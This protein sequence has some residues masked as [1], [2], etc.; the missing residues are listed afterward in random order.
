FSPQNGEKQKRLYAK[1]MEELKTQKWRADFIKPI[2]VEAEQEFAKK[3]AIQLEND[4][5]DRESRE[6]QLRKEREQ[7]EQ[8]YEQERR[9]QDHM[10]FLRRQELEKQQKNE[11]K[12]PEQDNDNDYTPW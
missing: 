10:A 8:R 12:K 1:E 11:P 9:E 7:Q 2:E 3:R 6:Q 5:K 4:R